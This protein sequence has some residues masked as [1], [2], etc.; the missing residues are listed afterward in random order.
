MAELE[1]D[2]A[3]GHQQ[4]N[5]RVLA[6]AGV[7]QA[8]AAEAARLGAERA[9]AADR[10][11]RDAQ[12]DAAVAS[13]QSDPRSAARA[14]LA[15]FGWNDSQFSC[16]DQLW[17]K[18]SNWSYTATNRSSGAYGIPQALPGSKMASVA[19]DWRTNPVPR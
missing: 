14:L 4:A 18:E 7:A 2:R 16:L 15:D 19:S 13:A 5:Q 12:R 11:A 9:A 3:T 8:A 6:A 17:Q 10:A 1:T